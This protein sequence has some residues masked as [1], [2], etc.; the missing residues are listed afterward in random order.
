[1]KKPIGCEPTGFSQISD[2]RKRAGNSDAE[3]GSSNLIPAP[4]RISP[5]CHYY[6]KF[7][8]EVNMKTK[9]LSRSGW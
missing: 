1:M 2:I 8:A 5:Y 9:S 3:Q 4:L 6:N 7:V